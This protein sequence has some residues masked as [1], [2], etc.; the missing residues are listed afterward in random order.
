MDV[1][2][3]LVQVTVGKTERSPVKTQRVDSRTLRPNA[4]KLGMEE[5]SGIGRRRSGAGSGQ[6]LLPLLALGDFNCSTYLG[7]QAHLYTRLINL[8]PINNKA[9]SRADMP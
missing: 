8:G 2:L 6:R 4:K 5:S 3:C 7:I 9:F 1:R